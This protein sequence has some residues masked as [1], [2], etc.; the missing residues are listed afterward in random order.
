MT[1]KQE[2]ANSTF[3]ALDIAFG[4]NDASLSK[5]TMAPSMIPRK[6]SKSSTGK[7]KYHQKSRNGCST[8]KRRRV[9]CDE[10]NLYV[11]TVPS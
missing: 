9:K 6:Q 4:E 5:A 3:N 8:C 11:E 2:S 7:R 10:Q 1:V